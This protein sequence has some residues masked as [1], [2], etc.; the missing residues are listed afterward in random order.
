VGVLIPTF[1][2]E[3]PNNV[4]TARCPIE[5]P[6]P[7]AIPWVIVEKKLGDSGKDGAGGGG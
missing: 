1:L 7:K 5:E 4:S 6:A 3:D 2:W